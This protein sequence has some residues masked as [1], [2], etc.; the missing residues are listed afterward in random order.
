MLSGV[1]GHLLHISSVAFNCSQQLPL[2]AYGTRTSNPATLFIALTRC[3][4]QSLT[5]SLDTV[6]H[7]LAL[8]CKIK[9][10]HPTPIPLAT[11]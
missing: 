7:T 3:D 8:G 11:Q 5:S 10:L 4:T 9:Q 6:S 2:Y 1:F